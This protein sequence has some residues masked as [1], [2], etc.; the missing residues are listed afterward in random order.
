MEEGYQ[1]PRSACH[2]DVIFEKLIKIQGT[3]FY[4]DLGYKKKVYENIKFVLFTP[5]LCIDTDEANKL[6]RHYSS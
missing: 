1:S 6:C 3:C 4:W 2:L 5:T